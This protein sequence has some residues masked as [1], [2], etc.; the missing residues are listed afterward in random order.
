[1]AVQALDE[2]LWGTA[3]RAL[4]LGYGCHREA[5][6]R[7]AGASRPRLQS[8]QARTPFARVSLLFSGGRA[9]GAGRRSAAR[10]SDGF[11]IRTTRLMGLAGPATTPALAASVAG[12]C[13]WGDRAHDAGGRAAPVAI[14][15]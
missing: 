12:R 1:M 9:P 8:D 6:L 13:Q 15:F 14:P 11:A 2:H 4:D 3:E 7:T 10:Q 5:A